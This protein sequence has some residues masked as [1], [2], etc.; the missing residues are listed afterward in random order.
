MP[1]AVAAGAEMLLPQVESLT[2]EASY[3]ARMLEGR[4]TASGER[5]RGTSLTAAHRSLPFGTRLRVT[6]LA[7]G[8]R[9]EVRVNDRGPF[10]RRRILDLSRAAAVELGMV[11]RGHARVSVEVLPSDG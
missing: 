10:H 1:P 6:N 8:R 2:G 4:P 3:Y 9:V 11:R 7:N 5:Y